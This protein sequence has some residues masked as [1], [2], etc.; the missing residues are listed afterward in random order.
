[1][2]WD[3]KLIMWYSLALLRQASRAQLARV[4]GLVRI[5]WIESYKQISIFHKSLC[6]FQTKNLKSHLEPQNLKDVYSRRFCGN[7][8]ILFFY[9]I[10]FANL[11]KS[12][13]KLLRSKWKVAIFEF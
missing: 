2:E 6:F 13:V 12:G 9:F 8:Q 11:H 4:N 10:I 5:S 1:M 3:L 7:L